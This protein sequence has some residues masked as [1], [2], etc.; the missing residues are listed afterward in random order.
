MQNGVS[1]EEI[2]QCFARARTLDPEELKSA[3]LFSQDVI[4]EFYPEEGIDLGANF[5]WEKTKGR[6][7]LREDELSIWTGFNGAGKSQMLGQVILSSMQQG[8]KVCIAS[9]ELKPKR[10]LMRLTRQAAGLRHPTEKYIQAIHEWYSDKLW[11]FDLV[12]NAKSD[13][14]LEVFKYARQR[15]GIT[16]FVIDSFMKLNFA[17]DDYKAHKIFLEKLADFKNEMNCHV[18]L[19]CHPRKATDENKLPGKLDVKGS[20]VLTDIADNCF[21]V[22]RN[23]SKEDRKNKLIAKGEPIPE[24]LEQD[25]DA[26]LI[27]DKNRNGEWEGKIGLWFHQDSFQ[28][29]NHQSQKPIQ[30]VQYSQLNN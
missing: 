11:I 5:P 15:Y 30:Y 17:E 25:I 1:K 24:E 12:G 27:C 21:C 6:L 22:F 26:L 20:G 28:Y 2:E 14:L 7:K 18:H 3:A 13:R 29:L 8:Y 4:T 19:V 9:L 10:L 23:K 16:H